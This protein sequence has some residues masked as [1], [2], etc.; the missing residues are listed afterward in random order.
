MK[1]SAFLGGK[2]GRQGLSSVSGAILAPASQDDTVLNQHHPELPLD[3]Q[4]DLL[5]Q[6]A[7]MPAD[8][9]LRTHKRSI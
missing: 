1:L 9:M 5:G 4:Y 6:L 3:E 8:I 2:E 7:S